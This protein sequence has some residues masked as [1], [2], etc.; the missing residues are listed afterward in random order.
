M[1][2][3]SPDSGSSSESLEATTQAVLFDAILSDTL[4]EDIA[5]QQATKPA[6][7]APVQKRQAH[8]QALPPKLPRIDH[9]HHH[10]HELDQTHC[11]CGEALERIREEVSEQLDCVPAPPSAR[12]LWV[13]RMGCSSARSK[14][15]N[16][17]AIS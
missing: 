9:H 10:H 8:R 3:P 11:A 4:L 13:E 16:A 2:A 6:P 14:Q 17:R 7:P 12:S 5:A 15:A 1:G